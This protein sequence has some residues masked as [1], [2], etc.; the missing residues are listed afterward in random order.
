MNL[1]RVFPTVWALA[2]YIGPAALSRPANDCGPCP[3]TPVDMLA[4]LRVRRERE[5]LLFGG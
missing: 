3:S 4:W 5:R 2:R 1:P